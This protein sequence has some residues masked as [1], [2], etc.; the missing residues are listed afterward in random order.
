[1]D[2]PSRYIPFPLR[3]VKGVLPG[4][5]HGALRRQRQRLQNQARN[6]AGINYGKYAADL[7]SS[8]DFVQQTKKVVR[9][10]TG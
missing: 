5:R 10:G 1:M 9:Y 7:I 4:W 6:D 2:P 8:N 3:E